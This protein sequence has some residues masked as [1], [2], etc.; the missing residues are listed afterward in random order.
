MFCPQFEHEKL[1]FKTWIG[2]LWNQNVKVLFV[3]CNRENIVPFAGMASQT[4][5]DRRIGLMGY[6]SRNEW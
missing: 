2:D 1:S 4:L 6:Q 3:T 5:S